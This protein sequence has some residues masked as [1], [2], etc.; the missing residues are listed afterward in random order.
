MPS[1]GLSLRW[2]DCEVEWVLLP[3]GLASGRT[4]EAATP[5]R[6]PR[7]GDTDVR[8]NGDATPG[9]RAAF[10]AA[11]RDTDLLIALT[12]PATE[13]ERRSTA[14]LVRHGGPPDK[15]SSVTDDRLP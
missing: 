5:A 7:D 13:L 9:W 8:Y 2:A 6:I 4:Y 10:P 11:R 1:V 3:T 15:H 14:A 12:S